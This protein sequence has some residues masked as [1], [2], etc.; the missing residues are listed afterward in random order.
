MT[1]SLSI[2][3]LASFA[4]V[5]WTATCNAQDELLE[6]FDWINLSPGATET[7]TTD[8]NWNALGSPPGNP[9]YPDDPNHTDEDEE[10]V[11]PVVGA[12]LSVAL[13]NNLNLDLGGGNITIASLKIGAPGVTTTINGPGNLI[14]K[15]SER[16]DVDAAPDPDDESK[17][18]DWY[19]CSFNCGYAMITSNPS[20]GNEIAALISTP[21]DSLDFVG[22]QTLVLSGGLEEVIQSPDDPSTT[23]LSR[24][25]T[26]IGQYDITQSVDT[27]TRLLV[28]GPLFT[29]V[30]QF[31]QDGQLVDEKLWL[32]AGG[33]NIP[34]L[35]QADDPD[36]FGTDGITDE[37]G[38]GDPHG[39][40]DLVGGIQG[41]GDLWIGSEKGGQS[42]VPLSTV[43]L[44][45]NATSAVPRT[46]GTTF[47]A[48]G[49]VVLR[50]D[51]AFGAVSPNGTNTSYELKMG[52]VANEVGYNLVVARGAADPASGSFMRTLAQDME[53]PHD[54][55]I[56]SAGNPDLGDSGS[57]TM[58]GRLFASNS[59]GPINLLPAG[60]ELIL[61]GA[62]W[63]ETGN[64]LD[65]DGS[66][67]TRIRGE[68]R[69]TDLSGNN[70][71]TTAGSSIRKRG[72]GALYVESSQF[73][74]TNTLQ[75]GTNSTKIDSARDATILV[76]G[77][78]L[79]FAHVSD[80]GA[81]GSN[82]RVHS[83]G[84]A[85][86]VDGGNNV[87]GNLGTIAATADPA[88]SDRFRNFS[89]KLPT[90]IV[91]DLYSYEGWSN[92]GLMLTTAADLSGTLDFTSGSLTTF[93]DMTIAAPE[94]GATFTGTITPAALASQLVV[95]NLVGGQ[96][97]YRLGGGSGTLTLAASK[98]TGANNLLVT[99]GGDYNNP[100]GA[101]RVQLGMVRVTGS[102]SSNALKAT[103]IGRYQ[104]T[105]QDAA[106][107]DT[108]ALADEYQYFGT[109]L[110][111]ESL[112]DGS[113]SIGTG[114]SASDLFIQGST[115]RYEG[116]AGSTNRLFTVGTI[117][118]TIDASG[119]GAINFTNA[120]ALPLDVAES[121]TGST[122]TG[123]PEIGNTTLYN[124]ASTSDLVVGMT[125]TG[126][127]IPEDTE[128]A[129]ILSP[130]RV[131]LN[132]S[133]EGFANNS[134]YVFTPVDR[135][136][137]L[138]GSNTGD[139]IFSPAIADASD[140][141]AVGLTKKDSGRWIVN[142]A[143]TYTGDTI[144]EAGTLGVMD[145]IGTLAAGTDLNLAEG[146]ALEFEIDNESSYD[147]LTI[148]GD[149]TLAGM[150]DVSL[151]GSPSVGQTFD[152]LTTSG[153]TIDMTG[154]S[155]IGDGSFTLSLESMDTV[156]RLTAS[157]ST[158]LA[159]DYNGDGHVDIA[160]YVVWR[161]NLGSTTAML[162]GDSTPEI[163]DASDYT[164][165]KNNFG[166]SSGALSGLASNQQAVPEPSAFGLLIAAAMLAVVARRRA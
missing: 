164:V 76:E 72:T 43:V 10:N 131:R 151:L 50:D 91:T 99:N 144:V 120:S 159:G 56:K 111:V 130:T 59:A 155:V 36:R 119:S 115:L 135:E 48:R 141:G 78:N 53:I 33:S 105:L 165:W 64:S 117:G 154:L 94:E 104:T 97:T 27:Q 75:L 19:N 20:A 160:D 127:R 9:N 47:I 157:T 82:D 18:A 77:G 162:P 34:A 108:V 103:V 90:P 136:L 30:E 140:G 11:G 107:A 3:A 79:H 129:A 57:L 5:A 100:N 92:G 102:N 138:R 137:T 112:A 31:D 7:W 71:A 166:A 116:A 152:I 37:V 12:N 51:G 65:Y 110:A 106:E 4:L 32:N 161:N 95:G 88:F 125:V 26:H 1:R 54:L 128:I 123:V 118:A 28:M 69:N 73:G 149:A 146:A 143:N 89:G 158:G 145:G 66:G 148:L 2:L 39:I 35:L 38:A 70:T 133:V 98:L 80:M 42:T 49:N 14:L 21:N 84:G 63:N 87:N 150:I 55:T 25:R 126:N 15:N 22:T 147:Q 41:S 62:Q 6:D 45:N 114:T 61:T 153:G 113:S 122:V 13:N 86:G 58:T 44:Y 68:I 74:N 24:F 85:I 132:K 134:T 40:M 139:N 46:S 67:L 83:T 156:L 121:R 23:N 81:T 93:Q 96:A 16:N 142:G 17:L 124:L 163:V 29:V 8:T 52:T 101:D 60:E 109:T